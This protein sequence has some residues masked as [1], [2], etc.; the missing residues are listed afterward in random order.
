ML[1]IFVSVSLEAKSKISVEFNVTKN[2]TKF[3]TKQS[4]HFNNE[5]IG[6]FPQLPFL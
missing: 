2:A 1:D 5:Q 6:N 4:L 3:I